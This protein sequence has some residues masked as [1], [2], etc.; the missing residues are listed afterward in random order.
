MV[1]CRAPSLTYYPGIGRG[2]RGLQLI[3]TMDQIGCSD[4]VAVPYND[5]RR[6]RDDWGSELE[7]RFLK[8]RARVGYADDR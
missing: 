5:F 7:V 6:M 8:K 1:C 2:L 4:F 3:S